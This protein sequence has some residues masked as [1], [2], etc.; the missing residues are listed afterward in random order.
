M[1]KEGEENRKVALDLF[2]S[3]SRKE[4]AR[5]KKTKP[6]FFSTPP[7][8]LDGWKVNQLQPL[9]DLQYSRYVL[10]RFCLFE[11]TRM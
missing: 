4:E 1:E 11:A 3:L 10:K 7:F 9:C 5:K 2:D 8:I 6:K